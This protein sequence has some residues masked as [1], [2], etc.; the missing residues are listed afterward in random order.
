MVLADG[1]SLVA[2]VATWIRALAMLSLHT[3]TLFVPVWIRMCS[4]SFSLL[5]VSVLGRGVCVSAG[6]VMVC[7]DVRGTK[8]VCVMGG[9]GRGGGCLV[10]LV[11]D[12][13]FL[14]LSLLVMQVAVV[15]SISLSDSTSILRPWLSSYSSL[16]ANYSSRILLCCCF[17]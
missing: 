15:V 4:A 14:Q 8:C 6:W 3:V 9:R 10:R 11:A 12:D 5:F 7:V 17:M 13:L 2:L 16:M 1:N